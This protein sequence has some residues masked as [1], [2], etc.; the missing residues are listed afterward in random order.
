MVLT[1]IQSPTLQS[2]SREF[3]WTAWCL[4]AGVTTCQVHRAQGP[5]SRSLLEAMIELYKPN[6]PVVI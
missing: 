5:Y 3:T 1:E 6:K 2:S 4:L